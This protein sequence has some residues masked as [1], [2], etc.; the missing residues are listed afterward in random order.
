MQFFFPALLVVLSFLA[1]CG[2]T[3]SELPKQEVKMGK[4]GER[5]SIGNL[6]Y[7][8]LEAEYKTQLGTLSAPRIPKSRFL[9]L[10]LAITNGGA[11]EVEVPMFT[12]LDPEGNEYPEEQSA[13]GID[14]WFGMIRKLGP[15]STEEGRVLFDVRPRDYRLEVTDGG[16]TGSEK[17]AHIEIPMQF[18]T[19]E[20]IPAVGQGAQPASPKP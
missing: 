8:I 7:T 10:R 2:G 17:L 12:L 6:T 9:I 14:G 18:D 19:A 13:E 1:G 16:E 5:V 11:K 3:N 4:M 20:P 15:T